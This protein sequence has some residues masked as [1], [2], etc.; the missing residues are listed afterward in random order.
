[1]LTLLSVTSRVCYLSEIVCGLIKSL[2]EEI[3]PA[4]KDHS[5]Q[6]SEIVIKNVVGSNSASY[7]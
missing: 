6:I 7:L 4:G 1:M 5:V 2:L 3:L